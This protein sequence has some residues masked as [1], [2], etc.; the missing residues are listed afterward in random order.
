MQL[1]KIKVSIQ[2]EI[3]FTL[4]IFLSET[5]CNMC[6]STAKIVVRAECVEFV[7]QYLNVCVW[8]S[9]NVF[10]E[11]KFAEISCAI[12]L[13]SIFAISLCWQ[14]LWMFSNRLRSPAQLKW[15]CH[16]MKGPASPT[17]NVRKGSKQ[18]KVFQEKKTHF[19]KA[20]RKWCDFSEVTF[21]STD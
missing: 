7:C 18:D 17:A 2:I 20:N 11:S 10:M 14:T 13:K 21:S 16:I 15:K 8:L 19:Y 12:K 4:S 6:Y 5:G 9:T 1:F 3:I